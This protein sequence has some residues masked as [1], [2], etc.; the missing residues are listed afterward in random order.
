[1]SNRMEVVQLID[2]FKS[3]NNDAN[4][5]KNDDAKDLS[6][7]LDRRVY[8]SSC[9][10]S[11]ED[12]I[13][14]SS[15]TEVD[16]KTTY[17]EMEDTRYKNDNKII[18]NS[19]KSD[20]SHSNNEFDFSEAIEENMLLVLG[21]GSGVENN[22]GN[23]K[24][25]KSCISSNNTS[26]V[27][28]ISQ[29]ISSERMLETRKSIISMCNVTKQIESVNIHSL[30]NIAIDYTQINNCEEKGNKS[31]PLNYD[32]S[33]EKK[34]KHSEIEEERVKILQFHENESKSTNNKNSCIDELSLITNNSYII[35]PNKKMLNELESNHLI[36]GGNDKESSSID[37]QSTIVNQKRIKNKTETVEDVKPS[38][39][40]ICTSN[41]PTIRQSRRIA[42]QKIREETNRRLIEEK[43]LRELKAEAIKNRMNSLSSYNDDFIT[44]DDE[45][46]KNSGTRIKRKIN[47]KPWMASSSETSS[48]SELE[49]EP[50]FSDD[51]KSSMKSDHEFSPESD[52]ETECITPIKRARTVR[53]ER[54]FDDNTDGYDP[55]VDHSCQKCGKIDNPEWILLCDSCDKGFHCF[56]LIPIIFI[57][58]EGDWY[59]PVCQHSQLIAQLEKKI[60]QYDE[61]CKQLDDENSNKSQQLAK[62]LEN[63]SN[64]NTGK[65]NPSQMNNICLSTVKNFAR[66]HSKDSGTDFEDYH[67]Y[68]LR[69]RGQNNFNYRFNDYDDLINSAINHD[70]YNNKGIDQV[71]C[72]KDIGNILKSETKIKSIVNRSQSMSSNSDIEQYKKTKSFK[73]RK[74]LNNLDSTSEDDGS[75]ED[76]ND[77]V[78]EDEES[79]SLTEDSESSLELLTLTKLRSVTKKDHDKEFINDEDDDVDDDD[80]DDDN[81]V[82]NQNCNRIRTR[83]QKAS[84][85]LEESDEFEEEEPTE[86]DDVVDSEDLCNDT[87][88]DSS[89]Y[90]WENRINK[91][92][93]VTHQLRKASINRRKKRIK[94]NKDTLYKSGIKKKTAINGTDSDR[95]ENNSNNA[96]KRRTRGRKLHFILDDDFESSD[97]GITPGVLRP[98]T[99]PEERERFIQKQEEIK[100]MLAE[101]NTAA[102]KALA[103]PTIKPFFET[104]ERNKTLSIVPPQVIESAK[105]LDIDY[106]KTPKHPDFGGFEGGLAVDFADTEDVNEDDLAKMMEDE[107]FAQHQIKSKDGTTVC[108]NNVTE[109][110]LKR[111]MKDFNNIDPIEITS[112]PD[113]KILLLDK[114]YGN[115]SSNEPIVEKPVIS[116]HA[117]GTDTVTLTN[118]IPNFPKTTLNSSKSSSLLQQMKQQAIPL[119]DCEEPIASILGA[120]TYASMIQ[121]VQEKLIADKSTGSL[122][123]EISETTNSTDV[124]K[125]RRRKK[126]TPLRGDMHTTKECQQEPKRL[127]CH[128]SSINQISKNT[129]HAYIKSETITNTNTLHFS[130]SQPFIMQHHYDGTSNI[131]TTLYTSLLPSLQTGR[132]THSSFE[133]LQPVNTEEFAME[134]IIGTTQTF[135]SSETD[136]ESISEFSGL[137][138]YF[139]SQ[140]NELND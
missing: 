82:S 77:E 128:I 30:N 74:K 99:P 132:S 92:K 72:G 54:Y 1:M 120:N 80:D 105:V 59:C 53:V 96:S 7:I 116:E 42:Q 134:Q 14:I 38:S 97:D 73:K 27:M 5:N 2:K 127:H 24:K 87:E 63:I 125:R 67:T 89:E 84:R 55:N 139:S 15:N 47:H 32:D 37:N 3:N 75:D 136:S 130:N 57:I 133:I 91:F 40:I 137:V 50:E 78:T 45:E 23:M 79:F 60:L 112:R 49:E 62:N 68:K 126:I 109:P 85:I 16:K 29:S 28:D 39:L 4:S 81:G 17:Q 76:F 135:N 35:S 93:P 69:R 10:F 25:E 22:M 111:K 20:C 70:E 119:Q 138:S 129:S 18:A 12:N 56:C 94:Q 124:I 9:S 65:K 88:T 118:L 46:S 101:K 58:P 43:M 110:S 113:K 36:F 90:D 13:Q 31:N 106:L 107:D 115:D 114:F 83:L 103:T 41:L 44:S 66:K 21:E 100:R 48:E 34:T 122:V 123:M 95:S 117:H 11:N 71:S 51:C 19:Q 102:A 61:I 140:R 52:V 121:S 104:C 26:T 98:D 131:D 108:K 8:K 64:N 86:S 33:C 6:L